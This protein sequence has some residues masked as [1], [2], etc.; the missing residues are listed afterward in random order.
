MTENQQATLDFIGAY[1]EEHGVPPS[2]RAIQRHFK[3]GSHTSVVRQLHTLAAGGHVEQLA[4]GSWAP[5]GR[6]A[7]L[8]FA[9]PVYGEIPAGL[10]AMREQEPVETLSIDP[11]GFGLR[12]ARPGQLWGLRVKGDSMTGAAILDGDIV[13]LARREP[14]PGDIIAALV[15][16]T[17]T[18]LK[19]YVIE[20]GRKK[21]RAENPRY[22][23]ITFRRLECQGVAV[24]VIRPRLA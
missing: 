4:N 13:L 11:R 2:V 19:R 24:G 12:S 7:Q 16:E 1:H 23:D 6:E 3:Y 8:H 17:L 18:T 9:L 14:R 5:K 21:L 10:P 15:D 20:R 22:P